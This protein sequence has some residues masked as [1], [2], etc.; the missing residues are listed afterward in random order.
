M[1]RKDKEKDETHEL[2]IFIHQVSTFKIATRMKS[3]QMN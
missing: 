1:R 3:F 2:K